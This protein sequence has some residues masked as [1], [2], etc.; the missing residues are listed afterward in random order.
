MAQGTP[1]K[2]KRDRHSSEYWLN[3]EGR[4]CGAIKSVSAL[5]GQDWHNSGH[6]AARKTH[7]DT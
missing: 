4:K 2:L 5:C 3:I 7:K 6:E 1:Q